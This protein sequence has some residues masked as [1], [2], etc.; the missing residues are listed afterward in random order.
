MPAPAGSPSAIRILMVD[1]DETLA[2]SCGSVLAVEGYG[3][4]TCGRG[5]E[6]VALLKRGI[7]DIVMLDLYM[8]Q[9]SGMEL[10]QVALEARPDTI[11]IM[12]TGNPSV[13]SSIAALRAGAW[14]YLP[15]PFAASH[16]QI[17]IGRAAHVVQ[18]GRESRALEQARAERH[19]PAEDPDLIAASRELKQVIALARR[20]AATDAAVF[21]SGESGTGKDEIAQLIHRHS[22]RSSRPL[23]AINCAAMP[24][25]LL[26]T[27][28]FGH[29]EGAFTGAIR[30]K[31]GVPPSPAAGGSDRCCAGTLSPGGHSHCG[32]ATAAALLRIAR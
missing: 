1:D 26:E 32:S 25:S 13:E 29:L 6:A 3:V 4:K 28:M 7:Y 20:V 2:E 16:L 10:L 15:K 18:V 31:A 19:G 30:D 14:D 17:L 27:E 8:T 12:L 24:E 5:S 23:V 22:R 21:L 9:V 11:V